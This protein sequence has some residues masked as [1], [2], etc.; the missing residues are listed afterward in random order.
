M[1]RVFYLVFAVCASI[2]AHAKL[3]ATSFPMTAQDLSFKSRV[4]IATEGYKPFLDKKAYEELNIV[5]GE[6]IY[7]D[8]MIAKNEA[9]EKQQMQDEQTMPL[10]EYC[11]KYPDDETK[12]V[13]PIPPEKQEQH[14]QQPISQEPKPQKQEPQK[15]QEP[16]KKH[17]V[18]TART[19]GGGPVIED[20][21]VTHGSC[22]PAARVHTKL[23]N[24]ILT[25]GK[26]EQINPAFEKAMITIFRKEGTCGTIK[27]DPC[28]YTCYGIGS[29]K[30]CSGVVINSRAEA[31]DWYYQNYWLK[32]NIGQLPDVISPD[33]FLAAMAS[34]PVTAQHQFADFVGAQRNKT[35]KVDASMIN[36]VNNYNGD[37]HNRW[38][39][40]RDAFLQ[41]V[42]RRRYGGRLNR[43]YKNSID[44]K[45][46]NGCHVYPDEPIYR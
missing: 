41:D 36:A 8:S 4:E 2:P 46:K 14:S 13:Q 9:D 24:Q 6:E 29:S 21:F 30:K 10:N 1:K 32:Y 17:P 20:N 16:P 7:T 28:G 27:G 25:T 18:Y 37:I 3:S 31:E 35:G 19:I 45:R 26:Y 43:G 42:S 22:Y 11:A 12:C 34:G 15:T 39:D 5:P 44:L 40:K 33:Y 38:M 23:S